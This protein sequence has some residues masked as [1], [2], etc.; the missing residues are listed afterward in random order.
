[1]LVYSSENVYSITL[2][3]Y[4][5]TNDC[6]SNFYMTIYLNNFLFRFSIINK[7]FLYLQMDHTFKDLLSDYLAAKT[8]AM[9]LVSA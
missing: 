1:M 6:L 8:L 9:H 2:E 4:C 7:V 5:Q 3:I